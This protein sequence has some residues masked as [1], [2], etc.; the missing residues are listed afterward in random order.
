MKLAINICQTRLPLT[1]LLLIDDDDYYYVFLV[2]GI[3]AVII[4]VFIHKE[5]Y[6]KMEMFLTHSLLMSILGDLNSN[7][8]PMKGVLYSKIMHNVATI[9]HICAP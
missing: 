8:I 6:M 2:V 5:G 1:L 3:A 4:I 9:V 7:G